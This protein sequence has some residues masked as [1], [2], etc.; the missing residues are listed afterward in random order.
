MNSPD[1]PEYILRRSRRARHVRLHISPAEGLVVVVPLRFDVARVPELL[2]AKRSWIDRKLSTLESIE[3]DISPPKT[4]ELKAVGKTWHVE[5]RPTP[6]VS[7]TARPTG[8]DLILSGAV[9]DHAK[10]RAAVRRWLAR[11]AKQDLVPWLKKLSDAHNLPFRDVTI[12]GQKTRWGSCSSRQTISI[13]YQLL[14]LEPQLVNCVLIHELCHT[15]H[16]NHG[17]AF[18]NLVERFEPDHRALHQQLRREW[19]SL[20]AWVLLR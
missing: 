2:D 10:C 17:P 3:H 4:I 12:R 6:S 19:G 14:F 8:S 15:R 7:V 9:N 13:N 1:R 5:Y 18:W 16:L 20:P 11:Q